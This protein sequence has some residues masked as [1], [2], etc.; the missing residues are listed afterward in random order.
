MNDVNVGLSVRENVDGVSDLF[1]LRW[2]PRAYL[3]KP[4]A[5][6]DLQII[7]DAARWSPSAFNEQPWQF[8]TSTEASYDK[9]LDVLIDVNQAW[10]KTAPLIGF[11]VAA[12]YFEGNGKKNH[13]ADFDAGAAWMAFNLQAEKLGLHAHAMGGVHYDQAYEMLGIDP[14]THR[15]I[16]AFVLGY[17]DSSANEAITSRKPLANIWHSVG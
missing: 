14:E 16:C 9:F 13:H 8:Y 17:A 11:V 5:E 12:Q 7:F 10:V 1:R 6:A 2:S 3:A 15:V 4:I